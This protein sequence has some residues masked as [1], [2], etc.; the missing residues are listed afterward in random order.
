VFKTLTIAAALAVTTA[1]AFA[2]A[3]S[4]ADLS[5]CVNGAL[6]ASVLKDGNPSPADAALSLTMIPAIGDMLVMEFVKSHEDGSLDRAIEKTLSD[7]ATD[8]ETMATKAL[9]LCAQKF[10]G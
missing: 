8:K 5:T 1:P 4:I 9:M 2:E 10:A 6:T 7:P 3:G